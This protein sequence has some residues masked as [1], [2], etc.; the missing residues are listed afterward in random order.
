MIWLLGYF[1]QIG[2]CLQ[3]NSV[4]NYKYYCFYILLKIA[5]EQIHYKSETLKLRL[6]QVLTSLSVVNAVIYS[7]V[8]KDKAYL[9]S[10]LI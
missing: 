3:L 5:G 1:D 6:S 7:G 8:L 2:V 4:L 10:S 9:R